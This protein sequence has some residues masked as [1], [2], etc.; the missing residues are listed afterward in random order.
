[1]KE[2]S[3][4]Q[5]KSYYRNLGFFLPIMEYLAVSRAW[6]YIRS[7]DSL[8]LMNFWIIVALVNTYFLV[9]VF[10]KLLDRTPAFTLTKE[11]IKDHIS[12]VKAGLIPWEEVIG[13]EIKD[14]AG[15]KQFILLVKNP[16]KHLQSL[17]TLRKNLAR[18]M[19]T[20]EGTPIIVNVQFIKYQAD[21]LVIE[22]QKYRK[23]S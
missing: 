23:G 13:G 3:I 19:I 17:S 15:A 14:Y 8:W 20:D 1:M 2:L 18:Q 4:P 12:I 6:Q 7:G 21:K 5:N 10:L 16:E 11:G 22:I 9:R